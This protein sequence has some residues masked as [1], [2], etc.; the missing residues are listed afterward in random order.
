MKSL[1]RARASRVSAETVA[2]AAFSVVARS[3]GQELVIKLRFQQLLMP[4]LW[5]EQAHLS[6]VPFDLRSKLFNVFF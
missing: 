1:E 6:Q 5:C 3:S 4:R 2:I